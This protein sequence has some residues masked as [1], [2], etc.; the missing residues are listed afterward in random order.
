MFCL[1]EAAPQSGMA[2]PV[3]EPA[4]LDYLRW[5]T[6]LAATIYPTM[7][8][9]FHPE[10]YIEEPDRFESVKA[11]AVRSLQEQWP[12]IET[13]LEATGHLAGRSLSAADLYLL[14]F[15][16]WAEDS[17]PGF[18]DSF[19]CTRELMAT[20]RRRPAIAGILERHK[21]GAWSD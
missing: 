10:N 2:P 1:A 21:S 7:M 13:A 4:R 16:V 3:G 9:L 19:P 17:L 8:R 6:F 11:F 12:M 20:L 14:M 15:A 18:L 5:M